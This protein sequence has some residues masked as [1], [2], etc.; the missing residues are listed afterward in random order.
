MR[1]AL[2]TAS[3]AAGFGGQSDEAAI[4]PIERTV[5]GFR[6]ISDEGLC[7]LTAVPGSAGCVRSIREFPYF[8]RAVVRP[9]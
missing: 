9:R 4:S 1:R 3:H 2:E 6:L 8:G 7:Y 5:N